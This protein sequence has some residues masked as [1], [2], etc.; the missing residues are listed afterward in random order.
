MEVSISSCEGEPVYTILFLFADVSYRSKQGGV[1]ISTVFLC[2]SFS[3]S[4]WSFK[5]DS[6]TVYPIT[7]HNGV[8]SS[9]DL[10]SISSIVSSHEGL[11]SCMY[12]NNANSSLNLTVLGKL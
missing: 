9:H 3:P 2:P 1:G 11:Y 10:L 7:H 6:S 8:I 4:G 5:D 12:G